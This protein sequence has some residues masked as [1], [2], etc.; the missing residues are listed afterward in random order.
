[1]RPLRASK[2]REKIAERDLEECFNRNRPMVPPRIIWKK[3]CIVVVDDM[4]ADGIS[5]NFRDAA[6]NMD[7]HQGE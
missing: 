3:K 5:E 6:T 2:F 1:M 7:V 4:V